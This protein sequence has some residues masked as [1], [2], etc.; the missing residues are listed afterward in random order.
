MATLRGSLSIPSPSNFNFN[1]LPTSTSSTIAENAP[2]PALPSITWN[3][4]TGAGQVDLFWTKTYTVTTTDSKDLTA[5]TDNFGATVNFARLKF[6]ALVNHDATHT[7]TI[8]ATGTNP[9]TGAYTGTIT[10]RPGSYFLLPV[11]SDATGYVTS[12]TS[13]NFTLTCSSPVSVQV[14]LAGCSV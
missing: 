14:L 6:V 3:P 9:W 7:V 4:G 8:D 1:N 11:A 13:K 10:I 12:G 5:L 2:S